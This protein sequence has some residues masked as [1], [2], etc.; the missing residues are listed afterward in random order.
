MERLGAALDA[1][2][3]EIAEHPTAARFALVEAPAAGE[4]ARE[5]VERAHNAFERAVLAELGQAADGAPLPSPVARGIVCGLASVLQAR[6]LEPRAPKISDLSSGLVEWMLSYRSPH[7][8]SLGNVSAAMPSLV[9]AQLRPAPAQRRAMQG[10]ERTRMLRAAARIA[11]AGGLRSLTSG[12]IVQAAHAGVDAF[13]R[14]FDSVEQCFLAAFE[15]ACAEAL[16]RALRESERAADWASATCRVLASLLGRLARDPVLAR[17]AFVEILA[18]GRP[19]IE[20]RASL[21]SGVAALL[22]RRTPHSSRPSP[23]VAEAIVGA[24]WG[25]AG[26]QARRGHLRELPLLAPH[27]A[28]LT[29]APIFGAEE[30]A[31]AIRSELGEPSA[32]LRAAQARA[33]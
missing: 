9:Q 18:A 21:M 13:S 7:A 14:E 17:T 5:A 8:R 22:S 25:L 16:A 20:R 27:A 19:G 30:A 15:L 1:L 28:Y 31:E 4:V 10:D 11:A 32:G 33:A 24:V 26:R 29:L 12:Q 6:L 23:L 2:L 3:V